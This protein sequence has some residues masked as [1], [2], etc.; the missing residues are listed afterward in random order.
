VAALAHSRACRKL[1]AD[2]LTEPVRAGPV[3]AWLSTSR[4]GPMHLSAGTNAPANPMETSLCYTSP[5]RWR[6]SARLSLHCHAL[7]ALKA[8]SWV[9]T[10]RAET[11]QGSNT[12]Y[13]RIPSTIDAPANRFRHLSAARSDA[14]IY[15]GADR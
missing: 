12:L 13:S 15:F 4:P 14:R 8:G 6:A 1:K 9:S 3:T 5:R 2:A 10:T 7:A 11:E